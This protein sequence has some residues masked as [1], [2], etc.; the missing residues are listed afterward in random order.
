M[1]ISQASIDA[2]LGGGE[3]EEPV[4]PQSVTT[5]APPTPSVPPTPPAEEQPQ[6][7]RADIRR[8][9]GLRVP[10]T[11]VLAERDM[12]IET[13]LEIAAGTIIEFDVLFDCDLT[14]Q[15]AD[16]PIGAGQAVKIGENFGL[17]VSRIGSVRNRIDALGGH[18]GNSE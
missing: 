15:V 9:L 18:L 5:T 1:S 10:V 6:P 4:Q 7:V 14:L 13:I 17:R 11:A 16:R 3:A 12:T 8:I 2:L